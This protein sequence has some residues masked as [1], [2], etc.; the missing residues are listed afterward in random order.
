MLQTFCVTALCVD[1]SR[2]QHL[3]SS[4]ELSTQE[5]YPVLGLLVV[6]LLITTLYDVDDMQR[7][8]VP[9]GIEQAVLVVCILESLLDDV[10]QGDC[11]ALGIPST[12]CL[13][14]LVYHQP[15]PF[16]PRRGYP[17]TGEAL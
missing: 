8:H 5:P 11:F 2:Y 16:R 13:L 10:R 12:Y 9:H 14:L 17:V 6:Y 3:L 15:L 1:R 7:V 4:L